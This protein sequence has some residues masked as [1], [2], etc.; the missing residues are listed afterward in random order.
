M[1]PRW[2]VLTIAAAGCESGIHFDAP[3]VAAIVTESL[4]PSLRPGGSTP[5]ARLGPA[6][7][8]DPNDVLAALAAK[9]VKNMFQN[10]YPNDTT[11]M[12]SP[13]Y[14]DAQISHIMARLTEVSDRSGGSH[15]ACL[16]N[17]EVSLTV[18][19][20]TTIDKVAKITLPH[21]QCKDEF[22]TPNGATSADG[23]GLV[24]GSDDAGNFSMWTALGA[25]NSTDWAA[26]GGFLTFA[27]VKN[28]GSTT[29]G[30][31]ETV[32]ALL[33]SYRPNS[34]PNAGSGEVVHFIAN[35]TAKTFEMFYA[36]NGG[37]LK[38][39]AAGDGD[40][41]IGGGA[42][43]ISDATNIYADGLL[44]NFD[45]NTV[46][47]Q[48]FTACID[49]TSLTVNTTAGACDT[50]KTTFTLS[51]TASLTECALAGIAAGCAITPG[52]GMEPPMGAAQVAAVKA[53]FPVS[54]APAGVTTF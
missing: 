4:P 7:V 46:G 16:D 37:S 19:L 54:A 10:S 44:Y 14:L 28:L 2:I 18:D 52:P 15:G 45:N 1:T 29:A 51:T 49:A 48:P 53:V 25:M 50:L 22:H 24:F 41:W 6:N 32:D 35:S 23:S 43:M 12:T 8:N 21:L 31:E 33:F 3:D 20:T 30:M 9:Y 39:L 5:Q 38:G 27:N 40:V 36:A 26:N 34:V 17:A 42:R 47:Y 13:G 11:M